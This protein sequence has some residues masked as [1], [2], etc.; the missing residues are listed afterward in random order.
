MTV[1]TDF[2]NLLYQLAHESNGQDIWIDLGGTPTLVIQDRESAQRIFK[3]NVA[4]YAKNM[5]GYRQ[6]FG[7]SR[8]TENGEAWRFRQLLSQSHLAKFDR[9]DVFER[10]VLHARRRVQQLLAASAGGS[11]TIDDATMRSMVSAVLFETFFGKSLENANVEVE[12]LV[13]LMSYGS[14]YS[15][16]PA[17][18]RELL[19][20]PVLR[21]FLAVRSKVLD[22][23]RSY[24]FSDPDPQSLIGKLL[25]AEGSSSHGFVLE[26]EVLFFF[27]AGSETTASTVGWACNLLARNPEIQEQLRSAMKEFWSGEDPDW[28]KLSRIG[29]LANFVDEVLRI[30]PV[31]PVVSRKAVGADRLGHSVVEP[32][33]QILV[34]IVGLQHDRRAN[35][36]PW[37]PSIQS[38][39]A[40]GINVSFGAGPRVCGGARFAQA[41]LISFLSVF[42]AEA[43]FE[44]TDQGPPRFRW[45]T[46]LMHEGGQPVRLV[47]IPA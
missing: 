47:P 3:T 45:Q 44:L 19:N 12:D 8:I 6:A 43:Q 7:P 28:E 16:V 42:L 18:G 5:P 39:P 46:L 41:E 36:D 1:A 14:E 30:F 31:T 21:E 24:R 34:S 38:A 20:A 35:P 22:S 10:S 25:A 11:P 40:S 13:S 4:N 23:L 17:R 9:Q 29:L 15:L 2:C 26:H 33:A 27:L 37:K 32:G